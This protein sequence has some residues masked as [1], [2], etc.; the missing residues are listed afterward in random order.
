VRILLGRNAR[1]LALLS[2]CALIVMVA[3]VRPPTVPPTVPT[4]TAPPSSTTTTTPPPKTNVVRIITDDQDVS[5][6][7][8][9]AK[10][11]Q[12]LG[13]KGVSYTDATVSLSLC[14]PSRVTHLTGQ[15]T[16]NHNVW[17][18]AGTRG[19]Y[20]N[21]AQPENSLAPWLKAAGYA[22][23]HVGKYM[24]G[25][26]AG[27]AAQVPPGWDEWFTVIEP[28]TGSYRYYDYSVSDNGTTRAYGTADSDYVTDVLSNRAV[29]QLRA[30]QATGKPFFLDYWPTAPHYGVGRTPTTHF[31]PAAGPAYENAN[32]GAQAPRSANFRP[33]TDTIPQGL[34]DYIPVLEDYFG[35]PD[36]EQNLDGSYRD[37]LNAL[38]S[39][40]DSIEALVNELDALGQLDNT[41]IIFTSDNGMMWGNHGL[42]MFKWE[43]YEES[44]RVP[45]LM[46][47]PGIPQGVTSNRP[48]SNIDIVPTILQATGVSAGRTLDGKALV[49]YPVDP[50]IDKDRALLVESNSYDPASPNQFP[51]A[52]VVPRFK[53]V[54]T[55]GFQYTE[56]FDGY[57]E[58][59]DLQFDRVEMHNLADDPNYAANRVKLSAAITQLDSCVGA[60]CDVMVAGLTHPGPFAGAAPSVAGASSP[61]QRPT[62]DRAAIDEM[63]AYLLKG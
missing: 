45:L 58:L 10:A 21:F 43:P 60:T 51:G 24:N 35:T 38:E 11:Q 16:H 27:V 47:G 62:P 32:P 25:Y 4:T 29:D 26:K 50:L 63:V 31:G 22:T 20:A 15:Y 33:A 5:S 61:D 53:A 59:F 42:T 41:L 34:R 12:Y 52:F 56:W 37:A 7:W 9:M 2:T 40:D 44:L 57:V 6:M 3:C 1:I 13:A 19:G 55:S 39:V 8:V 48:V 23:A 14:C 46:R 30:M 18:N 36:Y 49:P 28:P 17:D 54:R